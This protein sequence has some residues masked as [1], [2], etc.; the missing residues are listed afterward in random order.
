MKPHRI[1]VLTGGGDCPGLNAV[2]RAV[3]R[4]AHS[5]YAM[6]VV[7]ILDGFVG[8]VENQTR[9]LSHDDV[10]GLLS[11]GGTILGTSNRA[12]PFMYVREGDHEAAPADRSRDALLTIEQHGLDALVVIGGD[13]S[14]AIACR[15]LDLGVPIV[16]VPKTIDNDL[17]ATDVTF[18]FDSAVAV[19]TDAVDRLHS[20]AESHHR[21]MVLEVMG[22]YAGWIAL[23]AGV[24]GGGDV[25]VIPEIPYS[26]ESICR[27][28]ER[29]HHRGKRFSIVVVAEG[30]RDTAGQLISHR[31]VT[32]AN[33]PIRLGGIGRWIADQIEDT[34]GLESR[35]TV[36]GHLQRGGSPTA[37]DR[38]LATGFGVAAVDTLAKGLPDRMVAVRGQ[39]IVDVPL[40][41]A[42]G[43]LRQVDPAG[44]QVRAARALGTVF[45]DEVGE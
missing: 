28:I 27:G 14:Q 1:G 41:D 22:R 29:R 23:H 11:R 4:T 26:V 20:T 34:T 40:R 10:S 9:T 21:V 30:A 8:L 2:I 15:F 13:G 25:I 5:Q 12:D 39:D 32:D 31:T 19:A 43:A 36:L 18:G 38:W 16:G 7:G 33:D 6:E 17:A 42:V 24:A 37:Y 44:A 35:V 45:G 3:V